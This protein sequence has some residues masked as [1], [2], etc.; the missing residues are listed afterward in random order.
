MQTV[1]HGKEPHHVQP[2]VELTSDLI[3]FKSM[4]SRPDEIQNCIAFIESYLVRH[5]IGFRRIDQNGIPTILVLRP[6]GTA[7]VS[8]SAAST[9]TGSRPSWS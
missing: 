9:R 3:R 2:I 7:P 1:E 8:A 5:G 4:H 6:D